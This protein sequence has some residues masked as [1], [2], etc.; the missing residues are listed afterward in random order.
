MGFLQLGFWGQRLGDG[1]DDW[2][3]DACIFYGFMLYGCRFLRNTKQA[4]MRFFLLF[5]FFLQSCSSKFVK[6][7]EKTEILNS[8]NQ[9]YDVFNV[10]NKPETYDSVNPLI[11]FGVIILLVIS[12]SVLP[13]MLKK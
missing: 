12:C 5:V 11:W 7:N 6:K 8:P 13:A 10:V 9:N 4:Q 2:R 3:F 1:S